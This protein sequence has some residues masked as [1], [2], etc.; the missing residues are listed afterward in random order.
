MKTARFAVQM[1]E[2]TR[3]LPREIER[4][5][6][7]AFNLPKTFRLEDLSKVSYEIDTKNGTIRGQLRGDF[8]FHA[9]GYPS[10]II[11]N[12]NYHLTVPVEENPHNFK[13]FRLKVFID[14]TVGILIDKKNGRVSPYNKCDEQNDLLYYLTSPQENQ[15]HTIAFAFVLGFYFSKL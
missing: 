13:H 1:E 7:S 9:A 6:R 15:P 4:A 2:I 12:G 11:A 5:V 8:G 10:E 3:S 14:G